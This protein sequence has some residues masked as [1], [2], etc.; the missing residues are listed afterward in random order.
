MT[1]MGAFVPSVPE[2]ALWCRSE[3]W[4]QFSLVTRCAHGGLGAAVL[5]RKEGAGWAAAQSPPA[6]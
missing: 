2:C 6:T 1:V 4:Q 3:A 5:V